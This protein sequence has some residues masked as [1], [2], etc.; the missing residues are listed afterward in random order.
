MAMLISSVIIG[1]V[2]YVYLLFNHQ[3]TTY[4]QKAKVIDEYLIFQK[5]LQTDMQVADAIKSV[6]E[7]EIVCYRQ[8]N[9]IVTNYSFNSN[10]IIRFMGEARDTFLISNTGYEAVAVKDPALIETLVLRVTLY[11]EP[12]RLTFKKLYSAC[13]IMQQQPAYE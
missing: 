4:R 12:L 10:S 2:Y 8:A 7:N 6:S 3:F 11:D 13:Q 9:E 1:I 5:A